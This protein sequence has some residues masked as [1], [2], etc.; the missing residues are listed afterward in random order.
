M[1][2]QFGELEEVS[3][4]TRIDRGGALEVTQLQVKEKQYCS[5]AFEAYPDDS[6]MHRDFSKLVNLFLN[7]LEEPAQL[8]CRDSMGY[9]EWLNTL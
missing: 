1:D 6:A 8:K 5:I 3:P 9:P 2:P 4:E 7:A